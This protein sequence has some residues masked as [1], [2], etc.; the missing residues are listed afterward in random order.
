MVE[1]K[2]MTE[3]AE[4]GSSLAW[5]LLATLEGGSLILCASALLA[6]RA[7]H[8]PREERRAARTVLLSDTN[9]AL[10][11][12]IKS[13]L[14]S[15]GCIVSVPG[16]TSR[17]GAEADTDKVDAL[18][19]VGED[20]NENSLDGMAN[21]VSRDVYSNMKVLEEL[22]SRVRQGGYM[23]WACAGT[24][25]AC[26]H[27]AGAA[28]DTVLQ[29]SLQQVASRLECT[30]VWVGRHPPSVTAERVASALVPCTTRQSSFSVRSVTYKL[31]EYLDRM[32]KSVSSE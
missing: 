13:H 19:V 27:G 10:G 4:G 30:P 9:S 25:S 29:A 3:S 7:R 18:V 6:Y 31:S 26:F 20:A 23:A 22:S 32:L 15:R 1:I 14:E 12:E 21:L 11:R 5:R 16:T 8:S 17:A 2:I 28:F 24:T